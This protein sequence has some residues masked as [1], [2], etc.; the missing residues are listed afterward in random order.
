MIDSVEQRIADTIQ[1]NKTDLVDF[2]RRLIQ[3]PS[4][5]GMDDEVHLAE[6]I[7]AEA[8][9]LGLVVQ[10]VG[11]QPNRPNVIVSTG[12]SGDT[13]L[14]LLGHLDT[15]PPGDLANWTHPP[16]S[17][18]IADGR[19]YGRGA[20]DTKGGMAAAIY[21][22]AA[23]KDQING[24]AQFIGVPDE[25]TG[26]TGTLGIKYLSARGLLSGKGAIYAY[27]GSEIILGHRGLLRYRLVCTGQAIHTGAFEWQEQTSGANAV[28]GM[29]H[30]LLALEQINVAFPR[31]SAPYFERF[32]TVMTPGTII[33]G[34][35][36]VNIVPDR[37][38]A[39]IDIR[40]TPE[41]DPQT[42]EALLDQAIRQIETPALKFRYERLNYIP[43]VCSDERAPIF[44]ILADLIPQ[45]RGIPAVKTVAGP[46]NEGYLLIEQGIPTVCGFGPTGE[47][48][49]AANEYADVGSLADAALIFALTARRMNL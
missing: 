4:V 35:V 21:A 25:E 44:S 41:N 17:G 48:A 3:T 18:E 31:S 47:N 45:V 22:L 29:A 9:K 28:T 1:A 30:L 43:A 6:V 34:G 2:C 33:N 27:S 23:V 24:Q 32:R 16:F 39:L 36:S 14:L 15:V 46:A 38:E 49:H 20:I 11:E 8:R 5:N 26:A 37:C 7:A 40:T 10:I 12:D 42:I 13:D 19:I